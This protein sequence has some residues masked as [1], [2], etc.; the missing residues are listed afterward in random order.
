MLVNRQEATRLATEFANANGYRVVP[1]LSE[2]SW[3]GGP[4][5]VSLATT[6]LIAGSWSVV[7][8]KLLPPEVKSECPSD[9]CVMV[10]A[11]SG[12]CCFYSLL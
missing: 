4:R 8:D 12:E 3:R 9:M 10:S 1:S 5:P 11:T 6:R 2:L 7:F